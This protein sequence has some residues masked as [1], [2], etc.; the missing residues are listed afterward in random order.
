MPDTTDKALHMAR[1]ATNAEQEEM[2]SAR[3]DRGRSARVFTVGGNRGAIPD[4]RY[5]NPRGDKFQ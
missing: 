4:R 3:E 2:A 5:E 1:V